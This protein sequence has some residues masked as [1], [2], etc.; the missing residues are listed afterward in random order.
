MT[1]TV[2]EIDTRIGLQVGKCWVLDCRFRFDGTEL[3]FLDQGEIRV[4]CG[5]GHV[6]LHVRFDTGGKPFGFG[7]GATVRSFFERDAGMG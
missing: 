3:E 2:L 7:N 6:K 1:R 5:R 4:S